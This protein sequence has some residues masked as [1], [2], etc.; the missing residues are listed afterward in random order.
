[1]HK[2]MGTPGQPFILQASGYHW[3]QLQH[4]FLFAGQCFKM[5]I[6]ETET[7]MK[8]LST[9]RIPGPETLK[10]L[11]IPK[12][13]KDLDEAW[14]LSLVALIHNVQAETLRVQSLRFCYEQSMLIHTQISKGSIRQK[15]PLDNQEVNFVSTKPLRRWFLTFFAGRTP[16]ILKWSLR[17]QKCLNE[18]L[19]N[20][21]QVT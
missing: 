4:V 7:T 8:N 14:V 17:T 10:K 1:M 9:T 18:L 6:S 11:T 21:Q 15:T 16:K 3:Y 19:L 13:L 5:L 20:K 2:H 12:Q